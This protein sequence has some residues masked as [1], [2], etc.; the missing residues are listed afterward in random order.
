MDC[1]REEPFINEYIPNFQI[2]EAIAEFV[3]LEAADAASD[4]GIFEA[5]RTFQVPSLG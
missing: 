4:D 5:W 1:R 3:D 2:S